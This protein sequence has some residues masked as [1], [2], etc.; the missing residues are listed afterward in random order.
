MTSRDRLTTIDHHHHHE[1]EDEEEE[2]VERLPATIFDACYCGEPVPAG[3]DAVRIVIDGKVKADLSWKKEREAAAAYIQQGLRIFWEIDLGLLGSLHHPLSNR[4]QFLSLSLSLEHFRDT[5]WKEFHQQSLGLGLYRG[6]LDYSRNYPWDE[7]QVGNLQGRMVDLFSNAEIFGQATG[8]CISDLTAL[9]PAQMEASCAGRE[10]L[11]LFCRDAIGE[12][13]SLLASRVPDSLPLFLLFDA[14]EIQDPFMI[15]QLLTKERYPRFHLGVKQ[16]HAGGIAMNGGQVLGGEIAWEGNPLA[17]GSLSRTITAT[18]T[19]ERAN[20]GICLPRMSLCRPSSLLRDAFTDLQ[21]QKV[22]FRVI[23]EV[24]LAAEW[25]GLDYLVVDTQ[26][27]DPQ[28][29]RKLQGFCAAGG[30]VITIG[31]PLSLEGEVPFD[32]ELP[33]NLVYLC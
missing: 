16:A 17:K 12:Y 31:E 18:A 25:D 7:E 32:L 2:D 13:L 1:A 8:I 14:T 29:K 11:S 27:V 22:A 33:L 4:T 19:D 6:P 28:F 3:F 30:M 26:S 21:R 5:L 10:L 23:P 20:L 15:A 9:A 24:E